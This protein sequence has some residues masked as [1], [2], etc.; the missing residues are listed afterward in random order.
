MSRTKGRQRDK[1]NKAANCDDSIFND[2]ISI[3]Y[4]SKIQGCD[5]DVDDIPED[6]PTLTSNKRQRK[7]DLNKTNQTSNKQS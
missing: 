5:G 4:S 7:N 6:I 2:N 3:G 1:S